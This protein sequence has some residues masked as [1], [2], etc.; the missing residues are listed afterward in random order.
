VANL[1]TVEMTGPG[2]RRVINTRDY[3][4]FQSMGYRKVGEIRNPDEDVLPTLEETPDPDDLDEEF[5]DED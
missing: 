5:E 2:G 3:V 1:P 4:R